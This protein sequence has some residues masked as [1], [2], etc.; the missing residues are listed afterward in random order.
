MPRNVIYSDGAILTADGCID[1]IGE[2]SGGACCPPDICNLDPCDLMCTMI[3]LLPNGPLWDRAKQE[4]IARYQTDCYGGACDPN[5]PECSSL[6][7]FAIY[8]GLRV[9]NLI[10]DALWPAIRE[11][12][13][14]TAVETLDSWLE[15]FGWEG[16]FENACRD[17]RLGRGS[18]YE[19]DIPC[20]PLVIPNIPNDLLCAV[21]RGIVLALQ[22]LQMQPIKNLCGINWV[23][24]PL[25]A[26]LR[27]YQ[28]ECTIGGMTMIEQ[29][30]ECCNGMRWEL[31]NEGDMIE[32]CPGL[33]CAEQREQRM[34]SAYIVSPRL[35]YNVQQDTCVATGDPIRIFPG[36]LAAHCIAL[37]M[38]PTGDCLPPIRRCPEM[39][40]V[41]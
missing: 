36:V 18:P 28:P 24:A 6:V 25:G 31:C 12:N 19:C 33:Q 14:A 23:I 34:V 15:R 2:I 30:D 16:C 32:A 13:P 26:V 38:M 27:P 40:I 5:E 3:G 7:D 17:P 1:A 29:A 11:S 9:Y 35:E 10:N 41:N 39:E 20:S 22:R 8:S 4:R 37:S 21:K